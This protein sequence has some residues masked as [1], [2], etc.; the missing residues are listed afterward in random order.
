MAIVFYRIDERAIHGQTVVSWSRIIKIDGIILVSNEIANNPMLKNIYSR[1]AFNLPVHI[2][3]KESALKKLPEAE[4]SKR[5]YMLIAQEPII[6]K[7]LIEEKIISP[8]KINVGPLGKKDLR[9]SL[10]MG[11]YANDEEIEAFRSIAIQNIEIEF[12]L[13][14]GSNLRRFTDLKIK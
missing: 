6:L 7:E 5:K 13:L 14:P 11:I 12:Q 10:V 4:R 3:D 2:F 8:N 9:K 1:A